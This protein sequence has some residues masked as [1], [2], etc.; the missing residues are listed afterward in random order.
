MRQLF[1][2]SPAK[3]TGARAGLLLNPNAPFALA[4]TFHREGLTL[5]QIFTFASGLYFRGKLSYAQHVVATNSGSLIR[6]ITSNRGLLDPEQKFTVDELR[7]FG[8][9][10]IDGADP[11]YLAPI[12]RDAC[13]LA[14]K[15][16]KNGRAILLGS[17]ATAKYRD[18]LLECFGDRLMFPSD[19]VGR[20]DMSR[21]GLLLRAT[22]EKRELPYITVR[23]AV[24]N[25]KRAPRIGDMKS[26]G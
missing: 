8:D 25:G 12:R 24:L 5:G 20:G 6:V 13:A 1:L 11:R 9:V 19:F 3:V 14:R 16:G 22:R 15:L 10:D 18:I 23:G 26:P 4:R 7:A 17:I 21:G 2:L